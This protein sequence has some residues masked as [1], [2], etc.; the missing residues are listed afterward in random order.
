VR[1]GV[2]AEVGDE[3]VDGINAI[4]AGNADKLDL[5]SVGFL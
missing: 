1:E 5:V 3:I 4:A 2:N